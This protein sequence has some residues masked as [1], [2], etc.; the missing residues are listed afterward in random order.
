MTTVTENSTVGEVA[1]SFPKSISLF[2]QA[3]I[4]FCCGGN[5][6]LADVCRDKGLSVEGLIAGVAQAQQPAENTGNRDWSSATLSENLDRY[7]LWQSQ[8]RQ[9]TSLPS[10]C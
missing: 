7:R 3:G 8:T 4:D 10:T 6:K 5:K 2:Q 1:S 9:K